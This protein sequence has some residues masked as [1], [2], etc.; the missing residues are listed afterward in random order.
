MAQ[1]VADEVARPVDISMSN[2]SGS[3]RIVRKDADAAC[4]S[5]DS[6]VHPSS[7][8]ACKLQALSLGSPVP[9]PVPVA[10]EV[11]V[12]KYDTSDFNFL[13]VLGQGSY[14]KVPHVLSHSLH[15]THAR[16]SSLS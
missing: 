6:H 8:A 5:C 16:C 3:F 4:R 12:K 11:P 7:P 9:V 10:T 2:I 13:K 1:A 14:G 15:L